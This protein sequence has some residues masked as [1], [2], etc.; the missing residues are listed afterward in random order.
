MSNVFKYVLMFCPKFRNT[1]EHYNKDLMS[2][3]ITSLSFTAVDLKHLS[4]NWDMFVNSVL[5]QFVVVFEVSSQNY[6][7]SVSFG[8]YIICVVVSICCVMFF[9]HMLRIVQ[10]NRIKI[11]SFVFA[12]AGIFVTTV[13][14]GAISFTGP[15]TLTYRPFARDVLFYLGA[16]AW[17]FITFNKENI[18]LYESIGR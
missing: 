14:V 13:V 11:N 2:T 9:S 10:S 5:R 12:G 17:A 6:L 8:K 3:V 15:F 7:S 4:K 16:V 18:T 1:L